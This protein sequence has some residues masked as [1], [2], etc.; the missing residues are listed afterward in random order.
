M[1][2]GRSNSYPHYGQLTGTPTANQELAQLRT[3]LVV[4]AMK[5]YAIPTHVA[6]ATDSASTAGSTAN[7]APA[8]LIGFEQDEMG[9]FFNNAWTGNTVLAKHSAADISDTVGVGGASSVKTKLGLQGLVDALAGTTYDGGTTGPFGDLTD[10]GAIVLPD[11]QTTS[12]APDLDNNGSG[13][14]AGVSGLT[15]TFVSM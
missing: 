13:V 14:G 4:S 7:F 9:V 1:F 8:L 10:G 5:A 11:G 15:V 3:N 6:L 12:G 2:K